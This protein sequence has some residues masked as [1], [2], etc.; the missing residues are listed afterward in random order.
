[1]G[2]SN[3]SQS[4]YNDEFY[5]ERFVVHRRSSVGTFIRQQQ[6]P[7]PTKDKNQAPKL[8]YRSMVSVEDMPELF[9]SFDSKISLM[10]IYFCK[11][12]TINVKEKIGWWGTSVFSR[13]Y[14]FQTYHHNI[15]CNEMML[16]FLLISYIGYL[17][18]DRRPGWLCQHT[19]HYVEHDSSGLSVS[20]YC[21]T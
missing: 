5:T 20:M 9:V 16:V 11:G 3:V 21:K 17:H 15:Y 19:I 18:L 2:D 13:L 12:N 8:D 6:N 10:H 7:N 1:M 4:E 14:F